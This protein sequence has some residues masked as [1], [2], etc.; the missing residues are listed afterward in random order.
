M[1]LQGEKIFRKPHVPMLK[2]DNIRKG[3]FEHG[4]LMA[5]R[6]ALSD[7]RKPV[8]TFAYITG[9]RKADLKGRLFHDLRKTA[10]MNTVRAGVP[11]RVAMSI[12]GHKTRSVFERIG[13]S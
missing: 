9:W 3:F 6:D 2:E 11:E 7:Y 5:M 1:D 10:A 4:D 12:S 13:R 8:V